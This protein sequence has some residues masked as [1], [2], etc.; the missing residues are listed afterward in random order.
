M[1][2]DMSPAAVSARLRQVGQLRQLCL[3]LHRRDEGSA[4]TTH[5]IAASGTRS[6]EGCEPSQTQGPGTGSGDTAQHQY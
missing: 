6:P 1:G 2:A 5:R 4:A 3:S